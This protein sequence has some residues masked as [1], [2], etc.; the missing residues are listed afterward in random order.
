MAKPKP[1]TMLKGYDNLFPQRVAIEEII[2]K[3]IVVHSVSFANVTNVKGETN[4]VSLFAFSIG[5]ESERFE[6]MTSSWQIMKYLKAASE[7]EYFPFS[8]FVV[9]EDIG[10][11]HKQYSFS[12][13]PSE[14]F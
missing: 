8:A 2:D 3:E 1:L 14:P 9:K 6:V 11:G 12:D 10:K 7:Q 13:T 5:E 4:E